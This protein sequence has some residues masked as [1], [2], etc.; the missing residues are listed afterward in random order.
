MKRIG[1]TILLAMCLSS[2]SNAQDYNTGIGLRAGYTNGL[3]VKHFIGSKVALEGILS[4]RWEGV[5]ITGLYE[6]QNRAFNTERL[7]WFIG[8]GAHVGFWNGDHTNWGNRGESYTV[9][10]VDGIL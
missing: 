7:D 4:S 6:L 3:T 8:F 10:G 1:I 2:Y 5:E 9:V